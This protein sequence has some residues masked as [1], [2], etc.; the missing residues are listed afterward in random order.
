MTK[1][2]KQQRLEKEIERMKK[3][4][5]DRADVNY[6]ALCQT[7]KDWNYD[8]DEIRKGLDLL[9]ALCNEAGV[10]VDEVMADITSV[11]M[12]ELVM[13]A[14]RIG[15]YADEQ[16]RNVAVRRLFNRGLDVV[17]DPFKYNRVANLQTGET[18][19]APFAECLETVW[20]WVMVEL[21]EMSPEF[22][23]PQEVHFKQ[24]VTGAGSLAFEVDGLEYAI[25][26]NPVSEH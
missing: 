17:Y 19:S 16:T 22:C 13:R 5:R 10:E 26:F 2:N 21:R 12:E 7:L 6:T 25:Q 23:F 8:D 18:V 24:S 1:N 4:I 14:N 15:G 3:E 9:I 11:E 20:A